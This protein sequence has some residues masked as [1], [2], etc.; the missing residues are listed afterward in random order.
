[1]TEELLQVYDEQGNPVEPLSRSIVHQK[2]VQHWHGVVNVWLVNANGELMVSK[3]SENV[4]GNPGKWQTYFGG[5]VPAGMTHI[6]TAV[7]ELEEEIG[8]TINPDSLHIIDKGQFTNDDHLHF[9]ESYAL[10]YEGNPEGLNF[11]DGE[12]SAA[13]W[14][15]MDEYQ[16]ARTDNPEQWC[17]ACNEQNQLKIKEWL[18]LM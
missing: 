17:N 18:K 6:E 15:S 5:H 1:M 16:Q 10:L 4:G 13:K 14:M 8:L 9:Y 2:P 11:A 7:K 12:I 3:R